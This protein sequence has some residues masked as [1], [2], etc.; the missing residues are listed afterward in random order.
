MKTVV[1]FGGIPLALTLVLAA[2]CAT[3]GTTLSD[4]ELVRMQIDRWAQGL[5]EED[6]DGFLSTISDSFATSMAPDKEALAG[7]ISQAIDAGYLDG[8][9]IDL[10]DA[11]FNFDGDLCSVYPIDLMS[12][13]GSVSVELIFTKEAGQWM[14]T[15]ME[16]DGL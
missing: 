5:I 14:I 8:A 7:F 10:Q 16:V 4:E 11:Q 1:G 6:M 2:G 9:E 15:G 13:A 3:M 12:M